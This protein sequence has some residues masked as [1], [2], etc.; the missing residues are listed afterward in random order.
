MMIEGEAKRL[1]KVGAFA[2]PPTAS[3]A[4]Q[5]ARPVFSQVPEVTRPLEPAPARLDLMAAL[6]PQITLGANPEPDD[7]EPF[8]VEP[9]ARDEPA[10]DEPAPSAA[11]SRKR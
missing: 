10:R 11:P 7:A 3:Y 1:E 8:L 5:G 9:P 4:R 6:P 2:E